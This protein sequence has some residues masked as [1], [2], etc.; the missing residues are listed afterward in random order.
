MCV[1]FAGLIL[2][3]SENIEISINFTIIVSHKAIHFSGCTNNKDQ[4]QDHQDKDH[5]QGQIQDLV[6]GV[7]QIF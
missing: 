6:K 4:D 1:Q 7:P 2:N 5:L 3:M